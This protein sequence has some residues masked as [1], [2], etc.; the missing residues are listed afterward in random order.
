MLVPAMDTDSTITGITM[1]AAMSAAPPEE[2]R[3][4]MPPEGSQPSLTV[5]KY[6]SNSDRKKPGML[7]P[8]KERV[9]TV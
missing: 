6:T 2:P 7:L 1:W 9:T 8:K 4:V 5:N 3:V